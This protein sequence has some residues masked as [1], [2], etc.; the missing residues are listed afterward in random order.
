[1][2]SMFFAAALFATALAA[3]PLSIEDYATM[4]ALSAPQFSP[5][6]RRIAYVVTRADMTRSA[7][8]SDLWVIDADGRNDI[9]LTHST[10]SDAHP[11]WSADGSQ[12]AF[13]S[14]R[15][16]GRNA[17]WIMNAAGGEP[18]RLTNEP[19]AIRD[20]SW[21]PDGRSIAFLMTDPIPA[22]AEKR[23]K[24]KEDEHVVGQTRKQQHLYIIDVASRSLRR[25]TCCDFSVLGAAW[26][27]DGK[28]LAIVRVPSSSVDDTFH[29]DLFTIDASSACDDRSCP[30]MIPLVVRPGIDGSPRFSPDGKSVA[31]ISSGG[32][33]DWLRENQIWVVDLAA[34]RPRLVS[35]AY[36]RTPQ[37]FVWSADSR[38]IYFDGPL[39]TTAQLFRVNADGSGYRN[40]SNVAGVIGGADVDAKDGRTAFVMESLSA[41]PELYVADLNAKIFTPRQLTHHNDRFRDREL[42]ET[43]VIRW[44]NPKDGLEIEGL[45]TLPI[46]YKP[47]KRVPLLTFVHG[48]PASHFDQSYLGYLGYLYAPQVLARRGFAVL[49]PNPRG[50]GGYGQQF[51]EANR[52]DWG[53]M[54]WA[55]INAGIDKLIDDGIADPARLGL[56][57]W[58]YGGFMASWAVGHSDRLRAISIGAPVVDLLSF[59]GTTDIPEFIP[60]YFPRAVSTATSAA[61][62]A[63]APAETT[64]VPTLE[65]MKNVPMSLDVLRAHS[66]LWQLKPTKAHVLI[67]Q[68]EADDRVPLSQGMMF[69]RVLREMGADVSMVT[70][71]RSP[72]VPHEPKQRIDVMRRNVEFFTKWV[73][74]K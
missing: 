30:S 13:L 33:F 20:F 44:K 43:R 7:Y 73:M 41:P 49:R 48:G 39:N 61:P 60:S 17:I 45:L 31:F 24:E 54:D 15:E 65:A 9:Q 1:M 57:G 63:A 42:A 64:G 58:S 26:S 52:N 66:P 3:Q 8:D 50:T 74:G 55:D 67:Q 16:A 28:T 59:H 40:L 19:A 4:P 36:A 32:V 6:G 34:R 37:S 69:Y 27:P 46:G 56:M 10:G 18:Y 62:N 71:P 2:R 72:H 23:I 53:G 70:Y 14:D 5:D 22:E 25:M 38:A 35:A 12:L 29:S 68:G 21:S 11:R 51:R 47:G